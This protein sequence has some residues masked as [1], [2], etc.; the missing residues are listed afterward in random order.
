MKSAFS[1]VV[2]LAVIALLLLV[3]RST[4]VEVVFDKQAIS[5]VCNALK[6]PVT[7]ADAP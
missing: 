7:E 1:I 5:K 2:R 3:P 4:T 6:T